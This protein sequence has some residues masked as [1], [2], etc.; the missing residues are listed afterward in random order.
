MT[1]SDSELYESV[2][3]GDRDALRTLYKKYE[4]LLYTY[5]FKMT[6][7]P[8]LS[9]E[10]IQDVFVK[11]WKNKGAYDTEKGKLSTWLITITRHSA[12]DILRKQKPQ[13][14]EYDERDDINESSDLFHSSVEKA[15]E[16][17]QDQEV[18][19]KAIHALND[20][21]R[22]I[23]F[24]FYFKACSHSKIA[25]MMELPLGTVKSR[26]RLALGHLRKNIEKERGRSE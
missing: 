18:I 22:E 10:V 3:S 26:I 8:E 20:E 24:L 17:H 1:R 9:E 25:D 2:R 14:F 4:K 23:V 11:I 6:S 15:A 12:I 13:S 19:Q 21:Q 5:A 7:N 16:A